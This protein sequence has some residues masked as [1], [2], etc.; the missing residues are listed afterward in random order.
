MLDIMSPWK[1]VSRMANTTFLNYIEPK[2][3]MKNNDKKNETDLYIYGTIGGGIWFGGVNSKEVR[4]QLAEINTPIINVHI[5]SNGGDAFE[6]VA[7]GNLLKNHKSTINVYI[8]GMAASAASVI[9][10]AGDKIIMPKNA[11]LMVHRASTLCYGNADYLKKQ[12]DTLTKVDNALIESYTSRFKGELFELERLLDDETYLTAKEAMS[13]GFCDEITEA[14]KQSNDEAKE[15]DEEIEPSI[16]ESI[17]NNI[18]NPIFN[19]FAAM[20]SAFNQVNKKLK[21]N[22]E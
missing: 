11:M 5:H 13:Y 14:I 6:G 1:E 4:R 2:F 12:A 9:A 10:M 3:E 22:E 19:R 17:E 7:I 21:G 18:K 15:D 20:A 16:E 8:D